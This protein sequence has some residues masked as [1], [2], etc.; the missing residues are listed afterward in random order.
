[1]SHGHEHGHHHHAQDLD[2]DAMV[3]FAEREAEVLVAFLDEATSTVA[4]IAAAD[5]LDVRRIL[6]VGS[7]PG[8]ATCALAERFPG[9]T[10]LAADG[11]KEMLANVEARAARLGVAARVSTQLV[12]LPSGLDDLGTADLVWASLVLHHV[13]DE[14]AALRGL[15]SRLQGD[16]GGLLALVEFG[17]PLRVLPEGA[18]LGRP[19]LWERLEAARTTWLSEMRAGLPDSVESGDYRAMI[20]AAGFEVLVDRLVPVHLDPPL[21]PKARRAAVDHV[22]RMRERVEDYVDAADLDALDHLLAADD[23]AGIV[24]RPDALLHVSRHLFVARAVDRG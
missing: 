19:G 20:E 3:G 6:D 23:P 17:D 7:G 1:M 10:V 2:W 21:D 5:G 9:A 4:Q 16:H 18:D 13:G 12:E 22:T 15:R 24:R 11:S 14:A 8:V